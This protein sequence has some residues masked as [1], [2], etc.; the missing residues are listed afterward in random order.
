MKTPFST[1]LIVFLETPTF[2]ASSACVRL[3]RARSSRSR[4]NSWSAIAMRANLEIGERKEGEA[5]ARAHD[6]IHRATNGEVSKARQQVD[7]ER[8]HH[9]DPES[10]D[11]RRSKM[12]S[13][14]LIVHEIS[15]VP[16]NQHAAA[17]RENEQNDE[18]V[19]R[20]PIDPLVRTR[21]D[22]AKEHWTENG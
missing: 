8:A 14:D 10:H 22:V 1:V 11:E 18:R 12:R 4:F 3:R 16:S 13:R 2:A 15:D 20:P 21:S 19:Q 9:R 6:D 17:R 5:G 7:R